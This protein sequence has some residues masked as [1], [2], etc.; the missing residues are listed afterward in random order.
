M[1]TP[2]VEVQGEVIDSS[3]EGNFFDGSMRLLHFQSNI[4][5]TI[6]LSLE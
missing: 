3:N 6:V 4:S 5:C 1:N 2:E